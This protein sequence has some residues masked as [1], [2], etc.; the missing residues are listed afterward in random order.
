[1]PQ[2]MRTIRRLVS[3]FVPGRSTRLHAQCAVETDDLAI[4]V[5]VLDHMQHER[6]IL[7][8]LTEKLRERHR[9]REAL[10]RL[11][12]ECGQHRRQEYAGRNCIHADTE[13]RELARGGERER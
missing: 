5:A 12:G 11:L 13:L 9:G 4:E 2:V 1:M 3:M 8:R 10:L 7:R 6:G